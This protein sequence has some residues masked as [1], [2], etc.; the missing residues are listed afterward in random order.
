MIFFL[1]LVVFEPFTN[2]NG[3]EPLDVQQLS[4]ASTLE[5][6]RAADAAR[7]QPLLGRVK[8]ALWHVAALD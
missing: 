5:T 7:A 4:F 3:D 6:E 8:E 2:G 1:S